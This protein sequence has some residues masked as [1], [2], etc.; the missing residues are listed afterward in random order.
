M[1][2]GKAYSYKHTIYHFQI[3][4]TRIFTLFL[5][6][7]FHYTRSEG[8]TNTDDTT[9]C[10]ASFYL[11]CVMLQSTIKTDIFSKFF[12]NRHDAIITFI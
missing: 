10:H 1:S 12:Q 8:I 3:E 7:G 6:W 11:H 4:I 5:F 9:G 2:K